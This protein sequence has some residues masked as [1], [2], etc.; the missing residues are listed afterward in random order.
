[1]YE[2]DASAF[3]SSPFDFV[4]TGPREGTWSSTYLIT[5]LWQIKYD[6]ESIQNTEILKPDR[7]S[8]FGICTSR[9]MGIVE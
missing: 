8:R 1:M 6:P 5:Y 2:K 4:A 9:G 7:Q 3:T